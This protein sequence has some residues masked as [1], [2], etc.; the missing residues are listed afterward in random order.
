MHS[1]S[2]SPAVVAILLGCSLCLYLFR[3]RGASGDAGEKND[4]SVRTS[5]VVIYVRYPVKQQER[6][7]AHSEDQSGT[8]FSNAHQ[9]GLICNIYPGTGN[10]FEGEINFLDDDFEGEINFLDVAIAATEKP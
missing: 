10:D 8:C 7:Q 6:K 4:C 5:Y 2:H 9:K 3:W 1:H